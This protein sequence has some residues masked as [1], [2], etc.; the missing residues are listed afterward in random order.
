MLSELASMSGF[1]EV[2]RKNG[3]CGSINYVPLKVVLPYR[4]I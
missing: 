3:F 1:R 4:E 2:L